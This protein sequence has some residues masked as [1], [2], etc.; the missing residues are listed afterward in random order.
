MNMH[1]IVNHFF[2][3]CKENADS[4]LRMLNEPKANEDTIPIDL[5]GLDVSLRNISNYCKMML[6]D[7][8]GWQRIE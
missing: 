7:N 1:K 4:G 3:L 8:K 5:E 2:K 6:E